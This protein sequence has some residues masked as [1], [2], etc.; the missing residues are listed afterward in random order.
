MIEIKTDWSEENLKKYIMYKFL[1]SNKFTIAAMA[2]FG[3][4][5]AAIAAS[6]ITMF[7]MTESA[8]FLVMAGAVAVLAAGTV[9]FFIVKVN[10]NVKASADMGKESSENESVIL[11]EDKITVCKNQV[12]YGEMSWDKISSIDLNEKGKTAYLSTEEGAV[13][14]LEY[15]N[16]VVGAE[17]E[18][19]EMLL[20]K[21]VKLSEKA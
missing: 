11:T 14:I 9:I 2:V 1:F 16:I 4:C 21:N 8:V 17:K 10:K 20:I 18:L 7:A 12:P 13:L 6:C 19:R 15:K 5:F 3:I